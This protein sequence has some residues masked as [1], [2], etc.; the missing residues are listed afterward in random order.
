MALYDRGSLD[1]KAS[2]YSP[3]Y[4]KAA[5]LH[6]G[7]DL[8][9]VRKQAL[10]EL[11][12]EYAGRGLG[13]GGQAIEAGLSRKGDF[14]TQLAQRR[15]QLG[16]QS[17]QGQEQNR[18]DVEGHEQMLQDRTA[19]SQLQ[20]LFEKYKQEDYDTARRAR[21]MKMLFGGLGK[22]G[23]GLTAEAIGGAKKPDYDAANFQPPPSSVYY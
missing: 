16:L 20:D 15:Q 14:L 17:A 9:P 6:Y 10:Q 5:M 11:G 3:E 4:R 23:G 7:A 22:L 1:P 12:D 18:Q 21:P 8:A 19:Q 2:L 13:G